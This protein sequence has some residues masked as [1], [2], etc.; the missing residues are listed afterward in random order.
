MRAGTAA[1]GNPARPPAPVITRRG[2]HT[3]FITSISLCLVS[4][5]VTIVSVALPDI[6]RT[7]DDVSAATL[8]WVFTAYN[9]TFAALLLIAG[10]V[11]DRYGRKLTFLA[12]LGLFVAASA[13]AALAPSVDILIATRAVQAVGGALIYPA[14]LAL[15]LPE[16]PVERRSLALGVWGG[17]AGLSAALAPTLGA[18]LVDWVGW[19]AV[20]MVNVPFVA[21]AFVAGTSVLKEAKGENPRERFDAIAVPV[22]AAAIGLLVLGVVQGEDWGWADARIL[23]CFVAAAVLLPLFLVRSARHPRPLLDLDLFRIRSFSVASL[24]NVL[25]VGGFFG[26]VVL[27]PSFLIGVWGWSALAAGFA[28]APGPALSALLSPFAGRL[29][30]HLGHR[31]L[32]AGGL[33]VG[34]LGPFWWAVSIDEHPHFVTDMLPGSILVGIGA[35]AG[36]GTLTGATMREV[37][38]RFYSMAGATR[39][40]MFQLASAVG[41][42][43]SVAL[44]GTPSPDQAVAAY[45][46]S[47]WLA[48]VTTAAAA[49]VIGVAFPGRSRPLVHRPL[50]PEPSMG[51]GCG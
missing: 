13:G 6:R 12:G 45:A 3:L 31:W 33:A 41:I 14:S 35:A 49:V 16:F 27:F 22:A 7:F 50:E 10:K 8:S 48:A 39:S 23:G 19:R 51:A 28:L 11:A 32:V 18:L 43:L 2:W 34:A 5:D 40:T 47:W 9:I 30:D 17:I 29:A 37:P 26:W 25:F 1:T 36:F 44:L 42:A 20:F 4:M 38:P 24:A 15:L 21:V 46:R